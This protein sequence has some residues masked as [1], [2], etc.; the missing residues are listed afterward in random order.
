MS[1]SFFENKS[2]RKQTDDLLKI[3]K[4]YFLTEFPDRSKTGRSSDKK[5]ECFSSFLSIKSTIDA[6]PESLNSRSVKFLENPVEKIKFDEILQNKNKKPNLKLQ[7]LI[8][9]RIPKGETKKELLT[10]SNSSLSPKG[11][12]IL[13]LCKIHAKKQKKSQSP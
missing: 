13:N 9:D 7:I 2:T 5:N 4:N 8:P 6:S 3:C 11:K 10:P 12:K 1:D